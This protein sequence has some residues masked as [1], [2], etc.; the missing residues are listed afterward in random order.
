MLKVNVL[1]DF[2]FHFWSSDASTVMLY[3][4]IKKKSDSKVPQ[5]IMSVVID[6][7]L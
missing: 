3:E 6:Y 7:I 1:Y 5:I 4:Y 2:S